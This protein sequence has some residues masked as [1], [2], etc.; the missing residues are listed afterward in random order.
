VKIGRAAQRVLQQ[1]EAGNAVR[2]ACDQLS[3]H[4]AI[5][6]DLLECLGDRLVVV[7]YN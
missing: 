1:L 3:I 2:V 6:P 5:V 4:G 7:A